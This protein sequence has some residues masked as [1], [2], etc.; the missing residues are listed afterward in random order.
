MM[1]PSLRAK[2]PHTDPSQGAPRRQSKLGRLS[3]FIK[4][5][6]G[7]EDG[8]ASMEFVLV[9]PLIFMMFMASIEAGM[10][11]T[12][13][14]MLE[15]ALDMTMRD[16]RLGKIPDPTAVKIRDD[17]CRRSVL[18]KDCENNVNIEMRPIN[19]VTWD[20]PTSRVGCINRAENVRPALTY[21]PGQAHEIML[22][23]IC[24]PQ[25]AVFPTS[26]IGLNLKK[27]AGGAYGLVAVSAFVNEP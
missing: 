26:G 16:L 25:E 18:L 24:V 21:N 2:C 13:Y 10:F 3:G 14:I 23:R 17:V 22:V 9:V 5:A 27:D 7:R 8:T 4:T 1:M 6:M 15:Q 19:T 20:L 12:R 11:M